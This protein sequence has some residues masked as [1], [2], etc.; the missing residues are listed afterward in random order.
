MG[1]R[2]LRT[3][4]ACFVVLAASG[5]SAVR[6]QT[7]VIS[8]AWN[9]ERLTGGS[10]Q[11][12][13]FRIQQGLIYHL[14]QPHPVGEAAFDEEGRLNLA[15]QSHRKFSGGKAIVT[16]VANGVWKGQIVM[17]NGTEWPFVLRRR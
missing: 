14:D 4:A 16:K 2:Q 15:F 17:A 7:A 3:V 10:P 11:K 8:S 6:A 13:A 12:G 5:I 1:L 9:A